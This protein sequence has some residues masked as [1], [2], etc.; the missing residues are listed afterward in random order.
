MAAAGAAA[1]GGLVQGLFATG[2]ASQ[3][4][5]NAKKAARRA[6]ERNVRAYRHRY[7]WTM[8]DMRK[9]GLNPILAYSSGA[10][11][12]PT[13]QQAQTFMADASSFGKGAEA[14]VKAALADSQKANVDSSTEANVQTARA[15]AAAAKKSIAETQGVNQRNLEHSYI[16]DAYKEN[17]KLRTIRASREA[18]GTAINPASAKDVGR[19]I[20]TGIDKAADIMHMNHRKD[21]GW[22][23]N[24]YRAIGELMK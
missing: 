14:A 4:N 22:G 2:L 6:Y 21:L 24:L 12:A 7:Q 23:G 18:Y 1:A 11:S 13:A 5:K 8:D 15:A 17:P 9:A 20:K 3:A 16:L 19:R 10:G